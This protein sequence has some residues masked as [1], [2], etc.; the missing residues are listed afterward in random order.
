MDPI[1]DNVTFTLTK[2]GDY[3]NI[4]EMRVGSK[5][6]FKLEIHFPAGTTDMLVELF[7]PDNDTTVM[8]ICNP[9]ITHVGDNLD[10][11]AADVPLTLEAKDDSTQVGQ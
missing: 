10:T 9:Q 8:V 6:H 2:T 7:T 3:E 1:P 5:I 4:T 11:V